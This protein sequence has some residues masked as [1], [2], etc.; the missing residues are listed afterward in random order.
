MV[1]DPDI[2]Y[3][4]SKLLFAWKKSSKD[5]YHLYEMDLYT[6]A[7]R[8]ITSQDGHADYEGRYLPDGNILFAST[9]AAISTGDAPAEVSNFFICDGDGKYMRRVGFDQSHTLSPSV[10]DDGRV[11]YTRAD[12]NDRGNVFAQ[13]LFTMNCD[14]TSQSAYY[15]M[16]GRFPTTVIHSRQIPGTE[17]VM[18]VLTG[19]HSPQHGKLA[20]ID[21]ERGRNGDHA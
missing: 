17:R 9:R 19:Y 8:K 10:M 15:G 13:P 3:G 20:I 2:D 7:I 1:R 14:G 4:G 18:A 11:I 6:Q 16:Y 5:D 21:V 12:H